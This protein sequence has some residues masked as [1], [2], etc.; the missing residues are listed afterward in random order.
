MRFL[1]HMQM[2]EGARVFRLRGS[3]LATIAALVGS[4]WFT[5]TAMAQPLSLPLEIRQ[6]DT[7]WDLQSQ[8]GVPIST[9]V[10]TNIGSDGRMTNYNESG[11][12]LLPTTNQFASLV[13]F[14]GIPGLTSNDWFAVSNSVILK[15]GTNVF[16]A[17]VAN[18]MKLPVAL[19]NGAVVM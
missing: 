19:S 10:N 17:T 6:P 8:R 13:S 9:T 16:S 15:N 5:A 2:S 18:E 12:A 14:G 4:A 3:P 11:S 1:T 7:L